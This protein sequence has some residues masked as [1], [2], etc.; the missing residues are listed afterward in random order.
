[1]VNEARSRLINNSNEAVATAALN[2]KPRSLFLP[3]R[4]QNSSQR[5]QGPSL[6]LLPGLN[7]GQPSRTRRDPVTEGNNFRALSDVVL[8]PS[9]GEQFWLKIDHFDNFLQNVT[10]ELFIEVRS[11][12]LGWV[13]TCLSVDDYR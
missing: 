10:A 13:L 11:L 7:Q 12:K 9:P 8:M 1:M 6:H 3:W 4:L 2:P 5:R